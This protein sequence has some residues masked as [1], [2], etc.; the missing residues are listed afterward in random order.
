MDLLLFVDYRFCYLYQS[1][2][3]QMN[4]K[5]TQQLTVIDSLIEKQNK[6]TCYESGSKWLYKKINAGSL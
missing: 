6:Q 1:Q 3:D 4:K 5:Y 2:S